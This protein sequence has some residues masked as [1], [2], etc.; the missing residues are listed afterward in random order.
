MF[1]YWAINIIKFTNAIFCT[2]FGSERFLEK[3]VFTL[4]LS[5]ANNS[6]YIAGY[7]TVIGFALNWKNFDLTFF[8]YYRYLIIPVHT[9]LASGSYGACCF[10]CFL[11]RPFNFS[12]SSC[13]RFRCASFLSSVQVLPVLGFGF[14]LVC[15]RFLIKRL[16]FLLDHLLKPDPHF[17]QLPFHLCEPRPLGFLA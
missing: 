7:N 13:G 9:F 6:P 8:I 11:P 17:L 14:T 10:N 15:S 5:F 2:N 4:I 3:N 12:Q 1:A 16:T